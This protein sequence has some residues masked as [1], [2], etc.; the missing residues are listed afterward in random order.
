MGYNYSLTT[1][2]LFVATI[3]VLL[4]QASAFGAG[5]IPDFAYLN[6]KAFRHGD[7][8]NILETLAKT[9][10]KASIGG[11]SLL[12]IAASVYKAAAGPSK[13]NK[14][15]IKKVYFGNWLRDYSQ[16]M[17]I[18]G[19]TKLSADTLVLIVSILGFMTF[20][21][22]TEEFQVTA[23]RLGVYLPVEHIDNPKGYAEKEGDAR[24]FHPKLR[25]PVSQREL[26]IDPN[27]GMKKY[28][29]T[30]NQGWDT[31]TAFIRRTLKACIES[32][33][34]ANGQEGAELWE[35]YRLLGTG[36]HTLEDLLAHSNWCELA[37]RK[38]GHNEVFC[39]VGDRVTVN[40]PNGQAP[41]LVT[42]TFGGADFLHSL[43]GEAGDKLSQASVTD[44]S[45][46]MNEAQQS[47]NQADLGKI[48]TILSKLMGGGS[49]EESKLNEAE[50]MQQQAQGYNFNPD[51]VCPP[52]VKERLLA[53]LKWH[54]DVMRQILKKIEMVPGLTTVL[55]EFSNALNAYIYTI[56]APY[57]TPIL[58]Q[59]TQVLNEGSK[60]VIDNHDQYEVFTN[61]NASDPSHS[62]LSKDHFGLILNEPAGKIAQLVVENSVGLIVEAWSNNEN[63]DQVLNKILE[64][65]HHPYYNTG[66][67]QI[68]HKMYNEMTKWLGGLGA[69]ESRQVI[70]ALTKESV[71]NHKNK[72]LGSEDQNYDE[73]G[74]AGCS[75]GGST[76]YSSGGKTS[77]GTL[78]GTPAYNAEAGY[79]KPSNTGNSGYGSSGRQD[80][81][82]STYGSGGRQES[83]GPGGRQESAYGSTGR[84]ENTYGSGGRQESTYGS[85]GR[86][87]STHG[88]G[89][90]QDTSYGSGGRQDNTYGSGRQETQS[91]YGG[92]QQS[93]YGSGRKEESQ[94]YG[95]QQQQSTYGRQET[96]T[97]T[98][99][100]YGRQTETTTAGGYAPS[101]GG[102][103]PGYGGGGKQQEAYGRTEHASGYGGGRRDDDDN[104]PS[105][106]GGRR[107]DDDKPAYGGGRRD[108]DSKPSYGGGYGG[109]QRRDDDNKP[110]YGGGGYG[111]Q[112]RVDENK[113]SYGGGQSR[114]EDNKPSYGGGYGGGQRRDDDR[115][116]KPTYGGS[117]GYGGG[118]G[119]KDSEDDKPKYGG[120]GYGGGHSKKD[121]EDDKP[122]Y[123]GGGYGGGYGKKD[124]DDDKP[125]HRRNDSDDKPKYGGGGGYGGGG[126]G[127][128]RDDSDDDKKK[129]HGGYAPAYGGG[130]EGYGQPEGGRSGYAPAYGGRNETFGAERM[131]IS[132][133]S[134][135]EDK[136]RNKH[137]GGRGY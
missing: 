42:G 84:Q 81:N 112:S 127:G 59:T 44:L 78:G 31:S 43:L 61:P 95:G 115:D 41:P 120:G 118:H 130:G 55:E 45:N 75:H 4:P 134:D 86:Q 33:R 89:G 91:G 126:Y 77:T 37:L 66:Q 98:T 13:F 51:N 72:R 27:T 137:H 116:S 74:Y 83:H 36:L 63:P 1:T 123:G 40:T 50:Q 119:R 10:G 102:S 16:A 129:S 6:D 15:D 124:S 125:K 35:A 39:H 132:N 25:P 60:A 101:Y 68:Q 64:A 19:L 20:G 21:F 100:G 104:K 128:K 9:A 18:A 48:K 52:E 135:D 38:M 67:S 107:E 58:T 117:G 76:K 103:Q 71:Q 109:G 99:P 79:S 136:K 85:G 65:F 87:E 17:D 30:E 88:S 22:A 90:R 34:R 108:D 11:S 47:G 114:V 62:M 92:Q 133:D 12:G 131:K 80:T 111:G 3:C 5:D 7:I 97:S 24:N 29:A 8:E 53:L 2:F 94:G 14:S 113:P 82:T 110:S 28:M 73:P 32:G 96:H 106:G 49:N 23:D 56:L 46:K 70:Q 69:D 93:T 54:D 121:S 105:Y 57:V 122:K 26:E